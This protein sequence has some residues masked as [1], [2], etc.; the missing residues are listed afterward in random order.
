MTQATED[1][2]DKTQERAAE[3]DKLQTPGGSP[4]IKAVKKV[5]ANFAHNLQDFASR[6]N[7]EVPRFSKSFSTAMDSFG[8]AAALTSDFT[9]TTLM[10]SR[11][12]SI[13]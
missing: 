3:F 8:R 9:A 12:R 1:L 2:G 11:M 13:M 7:D 5:A 4:N 6:M 10:I